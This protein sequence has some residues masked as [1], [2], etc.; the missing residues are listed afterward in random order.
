M[1]RSRWNELLSIA[2]E[3]KNPNLYQILGLDEHDFDAAAIDRNFRERI[4]HVQSLRST[5][6]KEFIE[7]V[8]GELR[9]AL[10]ILSH[11]DEK[12]AYDEE[13]RED[14]TAELQRILT[15]TLAAG[16]LVGAAEKAL[17]ATA[18]L[19]LGM[20]ETDALAVIEA[21]LERTGAVR[22]DA[23]TLGVI[24]AHEGL[25]AEAA[26]ELA[27]VQAQS[28]ARLAEDAAARAREA[29]RAIGPTEPDTP[30]EADAPIPLETPSDTVFLPKRKNKKKARSKVGKVA[31][32]H[33][34]TEPLA[35]P[36]EEELD[37]VAA[38]P[39][40]PKVCAQCKSAIFEGWQ[41]TGAAERVGSRLLCS[42]CSAP[43]RAGKACAG[44]SRM[45][46]W[47]EKAVAIG[48]G[49]KICAT[50]AGSTGRAKVCAGCEMIL[51]RAAFERGEAIEAGGSVW[52]LDCLPSSDINRGI[53][54]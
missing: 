47:G 10:R 52:C 26:A 32:R 5:K 25:T 23:P 11:S 49:K 50:C 2:S 14:R 22:V 6:H 38:P 51:P 21:E 36:S 9:R 44:C 46:A 35:T 3:I 42:A 15:P 17:L 28:M 19:D 7:F 29:I 33:R 20:R 18:I 37:A 30:I 39:P 16:V 53:S 8:K 41:K 27:Q 1:R 43:I 31:T 54:R 45:I 12:A 24:P 4:Q 48:G 40:P 13:L 34:K